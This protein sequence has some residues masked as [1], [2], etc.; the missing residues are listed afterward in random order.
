MKKPFIE[1]FW[2]AYGI[3]LFV[4]IIDITLTMVAFNYGAIERNPIQAFILERWGWVTSITFGLFGIGLCIWALGK[5]R[6][7]LV[8]W[9][10]KTNWL[11]ALPF[12][13]YIWALGNE[14]V[15]VILNA[16]TLRELI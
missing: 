1:N 9:K 6:K 11:H 7:N 16:I 10:P 14:I 3:Y 15:V 13:T 12:S 2:L 8:K 4:W 5:A